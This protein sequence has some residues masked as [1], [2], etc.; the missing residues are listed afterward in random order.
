MSKIKFALQNQ[1]LDF[2]F[3][4]KNWDA[5]AGKDI[6]T[7]K[8]A[9]D[10]FENNFSNFTLDYAEPGIDPKFILELYLEFKQTKPLKKS[11]SQQITFNKK[12]GSPKLELI[13]KRD[14]KDEI[15]GQEFCVYTLQVNWQVDEKYASAT[16]IKRDFGPSTETAVGL[17]LNFIS[18][19]NNSKKIETGNIY[20]VIKNASTDIP[21]EIQ[22]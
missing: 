2:Y 7:K 20:C 19:P 3:P 15:Y 16:R 6:K 5:I 13:S 10:Y 21:F 18:N 8:E 1:N 22:Y 9:F 14:W 4:K 11:F 12:H 17:R